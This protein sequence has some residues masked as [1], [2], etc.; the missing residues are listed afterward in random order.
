MDTFRADVNL[1]LNESIKTK[2]E[3]YKVQ[4]GAYKNR[5]NAEIQLRKAIDEGFKNAYVKFE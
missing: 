1:G 3:L 4:I 2:K 5:D